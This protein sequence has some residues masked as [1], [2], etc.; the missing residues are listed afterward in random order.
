LNANARSPLQLFYDGT[1][2]NAA[3]ALAHIDHAELVC[4]RLPL[5]SPAELA[6]FEAFSTRAAS[7]PPENS[8]ALLLSSWGAKPGNFQLMTKQAF[9]GA[10]ALRK[11]KEAGWDWLLHLD[12]DEL[13]LPG[14][15]ALSLTGML[16]FLSSG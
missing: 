15:P 14:G 16:I 11:A 7:P 9:A 1:A 3:H 13:V 8:A 5:A 4:L 10:E 2:A 6:L 12:P